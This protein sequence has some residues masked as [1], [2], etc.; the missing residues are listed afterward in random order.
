M[1]VTRLPRNYK[2]PLIKK[3]TINS[4]NWFLANIGGQKRKGKYFQ[5]NSPHDAINII[6]LTNQRIESKI[7]DG[8]CAHHRPLFIGVCTSSLLQTKR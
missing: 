1:F 8:F 7:K 6:L 2:Q 5:S 3:E 4:P